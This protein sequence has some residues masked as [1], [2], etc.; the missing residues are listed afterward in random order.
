ML[1]LALLPLLAGWMAWHGRRDWAGFC[2]IVLAM[3]AINAAVCGVFSGTTHRYQNR[4]AW[5]GVAAVIAAAAGL[6]GAVAP[7][8]V[9]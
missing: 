2:L 9:S 7:K 8:A 1:A 3:L 4:I 6:R 5:I